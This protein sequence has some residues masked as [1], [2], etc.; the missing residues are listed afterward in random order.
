MSIATTA[1]DALAIIEASSETPVIIDD[2]ET[3][4]TRSKLLD[5]FGT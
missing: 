1:R 4:W 5:L 3:G 2:L